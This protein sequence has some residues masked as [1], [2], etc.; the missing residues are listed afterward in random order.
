MLDR[1]GVCTDSGKATNDQTAYG[2]LAG[3]PAV[4]RLIDEISDCDSDGGCLEQIKV[5]LRVYKLFL[6]I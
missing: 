3:R 4:N 6:N 1:F 2:W 5:E